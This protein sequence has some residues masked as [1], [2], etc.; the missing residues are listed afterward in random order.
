MRLRVKPPAPPIVNDQPYQSTCIYGE[1]D[2][3]SISD[4]EVEH[5]EE[6]L[7]NLTI[8]LTNPTQY[9]IRLH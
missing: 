4:A 7:R 2:R 3:T 6:A 8:E 9:A 5:L 1:T